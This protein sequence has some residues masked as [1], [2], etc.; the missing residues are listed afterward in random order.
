MR[1]RENQS[2]HSTSKYKEFQEE[3]QEA[4]KRR[5]IIKEII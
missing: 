3:R 1:E 4:I 5:K 2:R